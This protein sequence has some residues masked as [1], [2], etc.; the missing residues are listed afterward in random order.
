[1][2]EIRITAPLY[3]DIERKTMNPKRYYI[4]INTY[5]NL[6]YRVSGK[7]KKM[8][9]EAVREQLEGIQIETPCEVYYR[10]YKPSKRL[11]DKMN[12]VSIASKFLMDAIT[13]LGCWEDDN[14]DFIKTETILPT[15]YDKNNGR[16]EV[17]IR[18]IK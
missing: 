16:I 4:N 1:M 8:F 17:L 5:R 12:V 10:V 7:L 9:K 2:K 14:D 6:H 15:R 13:E 18:T 3:I 11:L